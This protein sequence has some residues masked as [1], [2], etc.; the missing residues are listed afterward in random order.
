VPPTIAGN[1][2]GACRE[3][4][5]RANAGQPARFHE[6]DKTKIP[7]QFHVCDPPCIEVCPGDGRHSNR[8][9]GG[10]QQTALGVGAGIENSERSQCRAVGAVNMWLSITA[11][12]SASVAF[13]YG[14]CLLCSANRKLRVDRDGLQVVDGDVLPHESLKALDG[15]CA[16]WEPLR[17]LTKSP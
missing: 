10:F 5:V 8:R 13:T 1:L 17:F 15:E 2:I 11:P 4:S 16:D 14:N 7:G 9:A 3:A 12:I 6:V